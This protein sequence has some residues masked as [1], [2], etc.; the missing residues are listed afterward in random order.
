M[1]YLARLK[2]S[3]KDLYDFESYKKWSGWYNK[4]YLKSDHWKLMSKNTLIFY[5]YKCIK[6]GGKATQAH[7]TKIGYL[8]LWHEIPGKHLL[9]ICNSCHKWIND[10]ILPGNKLENIA[11]D[12]LPKID[13]LKLINSIR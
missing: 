3:D 9:A 11:N 4:E 6:C 5:D 2:S 7:H 8:Y 1:K 12:K 10:K 13:L